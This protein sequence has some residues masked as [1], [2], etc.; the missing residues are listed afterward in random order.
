MA[1]LEVFMLRPKK[2]FTKA[3]LMDQLFGFD[4]EAGENAIEL[5]VGRLRKKAR[6]RAGSRSAPC[7]AWAIRRWSM[8]ASGSSLFLRL[9]AAISAVLIGGAALLAYAASNYAEPR[10]A[11]CL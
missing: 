9:M 5:Y 10:C 3:E 11:E 6:H 2:L 8:R 1:L 7:A 4:Q